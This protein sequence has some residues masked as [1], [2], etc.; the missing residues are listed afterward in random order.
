MSDLKPQWQVLEK[1][2]AGSSVVQPSTIDEAA[3]A[4]T[5][6][7]DTRT[8]SDI[9]AEPPVRSAVRSDHT[10]A[11]ETP[12]SAA[13]APTAPG[14]E[15]PMS[16]S[17][18]PESSKEDE[19]SMLDR[20]RGFYG[21]STDEKTGQR[22][23]RQIQR[24]PSPWSVFRDRDE[25]AAAAADAQPSETQTAAVPGSSDAEISAVRPL[26]LQTIEATTAELQN[27]PRLPSGL[28]QNVEAFQQREQDLR[29]LYLIADQPGPALT[30]IHV[31]P[32]AEQE[33]WQEI[34]L[35]LAQYRSRDDGVS[36]EQRFTSTVGQM[37][38]AVRRLMPL[39]A[40]KI[41]RM[42]ICSQIYSFGRVETF[43][44]NSFDPGQPILL[45][46]ELENFTSRMTMNGSYETNF[47]ALLRI[48]HQGRD[49]PIESISL[50]DI[51]DESTSERVDYFQ[52]FELN[53]PSHLDSGSYRIELRLRDRNSGK[54]TSGEVEFRIR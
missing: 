3:V 21:P 18:K 26:L 8:V 19:P 43:L 22:W 20:L 24:L 11:Q 41:R 36:Q 16:E 34:M 27:W 10:G 51:S 42:D 33:F 23:M 5:I 25:A 6:R 37:Q 53:V 49:E 28:P 52:S 7:P 40:L 12:P 48:F 39:A 54:I 38:S 4:P 14:T 44:T 50:P 9:G 30:A 45:Y 29:L 1:P 17:A 35:A 32:P 2:Q 13:R 15:P 46:V 31:L 47:E